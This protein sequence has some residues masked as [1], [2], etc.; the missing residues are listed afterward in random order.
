M[1]R[2]QIAPYRQKH[3]RYVSLQTGSQVETLITRPFVVQGD[4]LR[5]NVDASRGAIRVGIGEYK[6]VDLGQGLGDGVHGGGTPST[7]PYLM[8][9]NVLPGLA[10]R[11]AV[12]S[13]PAGIN[14][15]VEFKGGKSLAALRGRTVVLFIEAVDS[16]IYGFR[17]E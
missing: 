11:T 14:V 6:P 7:D 10:G 15:A 12:R 16:D 1:R 13:K 3:D 2:C 8:E 5:L 9:Q 17:V 4:T